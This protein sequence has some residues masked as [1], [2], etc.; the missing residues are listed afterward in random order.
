LEALQKRR[1]AFPTSSSTGEIVALG[2]NGAPDFAALQAA[3][4]ER[5]TKD[6]IFFAFDLLFVGSVDLRKLPLS[7][8]KERLS[9]MLGEVDRGE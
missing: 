6:L 7:E 5:R 8:R 3:L 2:K 1:P 4:S 9:E